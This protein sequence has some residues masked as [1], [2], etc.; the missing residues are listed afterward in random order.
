LEDD[1][2]DLDDQELDDEDLDDYINISEEQKE[3][4][5]RDQ[6]LKE[7]YEA[8]TQ[9]MEDNSEENQID[10]PK[11]LKC[12]LREYQKTAL[13]WMLNREIKGNDG[14]EKKLHPLYLEKKFQDGTLFYFNPF[15]GILTL[16]FIQAPP[17]PKGGILADEMGLGKT[18]KPLT[19]I[20]RN[21][22]KCWLFSWQINQKCPFQNTIKKLASMTLDLLLLFVR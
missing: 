7:L 21:Q 11:D 8:V 9:S 5:E 10:V 6:Q 1:D 14:Q 3:N 20:K 4:M 22:L 13:R 2:D 12:D 19:F 18:G 16:T 17:D 15:G